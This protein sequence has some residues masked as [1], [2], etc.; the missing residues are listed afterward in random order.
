MGRVLTNNIS[1]AYAIETSLGTPGTTW[2]L[3]EPNTIPNYGANIATTQRQPISKD[4]QERKGTITDLDSGVEFEHDLTLSAF[5]DFVEAFL[6]AT[7][8]NSD[9]V[10]KGANATGTGYT[11]PSATAAQGAKFQFG[12]TA[13]KS[14]IYARGYVTSANNGLKVLGADVAQT[15]TEITVS[16]LSAETAPSSAE[17]ELAGV[18]ANT[19]DLD[20]TVAAGVATIT[21]DNGG[22]TAIDF[23]TLGL[24]VG[25]VIHV[26]GLTATNQFGN[27]AGYGR[28]TSIAANTLVLDK[29]SSALATDGGSGKDID[30]LFGRFIR[31]VNV[32]ASDYLTR[33]FHFE[34]GFE[35]LGSGGGTRYEY[36]KGNYPNTLVFNLPLNGKALTTFNFVGTDT[37]VPTDTQ[38]SGADSPVSPN[39]TAA[40]N[41]T[42]DIARLR[43]TDVDES[44]LTTDFKSL[45]L[46]INN[47]VGPE[48]V[49]AQ[50][51]AKYMN[52]GNFNIGI[53]SQIVFSNEDVVT[54]IR[55]NTTVTMDFLL[56]NDDGGLFVDVASM[57][58]G[59][60]GKEFPVNESVLANLTGTAFKDATLGTSIGVSLFPVLP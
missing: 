39:K 24:T 48:K 18:R 36:A 34:A 32:D 4:R 50:L 60:G 37:D 22:G 11:I 52:T 35:N 12:A 38:K 47:N 28:I 14:L 23:T 55:N 27:G 54:R 10:F 13:P 9:M 49:L 42:S 40:F 33:S 30:L 8:V 53:E 59:G 58:L 43:V 25:Q 57:N 7:A 5:V 3:L 29:L 2:N 15:D 26:G 6:F 46:T 31:N 51:G 1:L 41:T 21:S 20:I 16:G 17:V 45:S 56:K 44:G 19:S